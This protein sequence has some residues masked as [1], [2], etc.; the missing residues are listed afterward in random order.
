M[1]IKTSNRWKTIY[2]TRTGNA[3]F[4][5]RNQR[6]HLSEFMRLDSKQDSEWDGYKGLSNSHAM[7][8]KLSSC[9]EAV[10]TAII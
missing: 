6:W 5:Y 10:K 2:Y 7:M 1:T 9:G 8:I 4:I 3:Y